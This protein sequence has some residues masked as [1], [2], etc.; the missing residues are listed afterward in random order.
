MLLD[1]STALYTKYDDDALSV[2]GKKPESSLYLGRCQVDTPHELVATI[3][4][5]VTKRRASFDKVVDF[6]A[7]DARFAT[8]G[9]Y[10]N[11]IG[12]E[13]DRL[14]CSVTTLPPKAKIVN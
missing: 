12:Y 5:L 4:Q 8:G 11:Y 1:R 14:R 13:I 10:R 7:G 6:G 2:L 9:R 3:W